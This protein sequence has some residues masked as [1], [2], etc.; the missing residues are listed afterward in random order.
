[1]PYR[2]LTH[3]ATAGRL[4]PDAGP[5]PAGRDRRRLDLPGRGRRPSD[6]ATGPVRVATFTPT[7]ALDPYA[8]CAVLFNPPHDLSVTDLAGNPLIERFLCPG[9]GGTPPA[10]CL[11]PWTT[12]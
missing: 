12:L 4:L 7:A 6:C 10:L 2:R 8:K 11:D 9:R 5:G 1:M 3:R